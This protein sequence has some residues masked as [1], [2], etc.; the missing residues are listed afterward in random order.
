[1]HQM[2]MPSNSLIHRLIL[3]QC[4]CQVARPL[5]A[6]VTLQSFDSGDTGGHR[7]SI[8]STSALLYS[9][10]ASS[11]FS[12]CSSSLHT[13]ELLMS[14]NTLI[15][16]SFSVISCFTCTNRTNRTIDINSARKG[17][18]ARARLSFAHQAVQGLTCAKIRIQECYLGEHIGP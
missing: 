18:L 4:H 5:W 8:D 14:R 12:C 10:T 16:M 15:S 1:M 13:G 11:R 7:V 6:L 3:S 17:V 2:H 9:S